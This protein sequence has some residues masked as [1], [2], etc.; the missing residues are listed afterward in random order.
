MGVQPVRSSWAYHC[1]LSPTNVSS[2]RKYQVPPSSSRFTC[3][4]LMS[5]FPP[6]SSAVCATA[7]AGQKAAKATRIV[8]ARLAKRRRVAAFVDAV[9]WVI[10]IATVRPGHAPPSSP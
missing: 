8:S 5:G 1:S 10:A 6:G 4:S 7:D 3:P 2:W 9:L